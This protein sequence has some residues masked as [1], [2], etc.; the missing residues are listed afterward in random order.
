MFGTDVVKAIG[1][2]FLISLVVRIIGFVKEALIASI[3]GLSAIVDVYVLTLLMATYFVNPVAGSISTPLTVSLR[4]FEK[5][6]KHWAQTVIVT[7]TMS[8]CLL[9]MIVTALLSGV[10]SANFSNFEQFFQSENVKIAGL[11]KYM[12]L[13]GL[14][15]AFAILADSV[16]AAQSRFG[17]QSS[18]KLCVPFT[19]ILSCFFA[20]TNFLIEAL[21]IG[22]IAGYFIESLASAICIRRVLTLP[23]I[24]TIF[25]FDF[26]FNQLLRQWPALAASG[27][28][29]SACLVVDQTMAVLAGE[30][31]V[32]V[33]SFGNRLTMGLL[34]LASDLWIVLFPQF[35]D[36][37]TQKNF[38]QL[39]KSFIGLNLCIIGFGFLGCVL[40]S[41][42]SD[43]LTMSLYQRGAFTS[44]DTEIVSKVQIF[45]FL[46]IPFYISIFINTRIVNAFEKPKLYFF[47]NAA[48]LACNIFFNLILIKAFGVI[49]IAISTLIS[50]AALAFFWFYVTLQLIRRSDTP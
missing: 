40:L 33:I 38:Q 1:I 49:G 45:Y 10:A 13:I 41:F 9:I 15:S 30:G 27:L 50:Y 16:L 21:F 24:H 44:Q 48:L 2:S 39:R 28:V 37:V 17:L 31:A 3:F 4:R 7:K 22:T 43:W 6:G 18:I 29:M 20:P 8:V 14:F 46:H 35:I 23:T 11:H 5:S 25:R 47:G 19:I 32:A 34:S 42:L 36:Q 26:E 12:L